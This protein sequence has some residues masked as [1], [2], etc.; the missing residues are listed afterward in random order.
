[1]LEIEKSKN[2]SISQFNKYVLNILNK[3]KV[4][5]ISDNIIDMITNTKETQSQYT[6]TPENRLR[7]AGEAAGKLLDLNTRLMNQIVLSKSQDS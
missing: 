5:V 3:Y 2:I 6:I 7:V 4:K 1:M